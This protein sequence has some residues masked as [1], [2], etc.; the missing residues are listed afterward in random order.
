MFWP[1]LENGIQPTSPTHII[2]GLE[3][4]ELKEDKEKVNRQH[5]RYS[6][7]TQVQ[8]TDAHL[9]LERKLR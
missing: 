4:T 3:A 7:Q 6:E 9:A 1:S 5:R 2:K 8:A